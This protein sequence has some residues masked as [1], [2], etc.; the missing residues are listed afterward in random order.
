MKELIKNNLQVRKIWKRKFVTTREN[1]SYWYSQQ[2]NKQNI[3]NYRYV[4][5]SKF[6]G[7]LGIEY[8]EVD[9]VVPKDENE[10]WMSF[11][12]EDS[13]GLT[14]TGQKLLQMAAE[15]YVYSVLGSQVQTRWSIVGSGAKSS[16]T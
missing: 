3:R 1:L 5:G 13:D 10:D 9:H 6:S 14:K 15:S 16:Q 12:K 2:Q 4:T 8:E 7:V 11:V